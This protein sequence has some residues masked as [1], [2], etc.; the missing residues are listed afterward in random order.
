MG[1]GVTANGSRISFWSGESVLKLMGA[2]SVNRLKTEL[3][4]LNE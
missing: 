3:H 2:S 1:R 4:I